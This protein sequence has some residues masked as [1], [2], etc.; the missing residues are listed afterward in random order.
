MS[1]SD[2]IAAQ[3]LANSAE[4]PYL[5]HCDHL[6]VIRAHGEEAGHYLQGQVSCDLREVD[7]QGHRNG[8]HLT[9]KGRGLVSARIVRDGDD[10]LL[11]CPADLSEAVIKALMK[12]RLRAKVEFSVDQELVVLGLAGNLP[13]GAPDHGNSAETDQGLWL[14]YPFTDHALLLVKQDAAEHAWQTLAA[15]RATTGANGWQLADI[16]A[17]EGMV[18]PGAQDLFLPQVLNY[19]VTA[20]VNFKKGCYTGQEVVARMHFKGKLKQRMQRINYSADVDLTPGETLRDSN[21][22]AAGEVVSAARTSQGGAAL[23]V[24]RKDTDG[25][26]FREELALDSQLGALP[27]SLP[28]KE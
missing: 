14:R 18:Y 8:M 26:L 19:D 28:W 25:V 16:D 7:Q 23:V 10:Y 20:G 13:A 5:S 22:K 15:D 2:F 24:L 9:L 12:Y 17:G 4:T 1:W 21:G 27:Y 6:A 11:L 3:A